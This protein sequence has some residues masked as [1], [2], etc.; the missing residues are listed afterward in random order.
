M[1]TIVPIT[2]TAY[3][4]KCP[5]CGTEQ[6]GYDEPVFVVVCEKCDTEFGFE[7]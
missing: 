4:W 1:E 7:A 6:D 2:I 3:K 5:E